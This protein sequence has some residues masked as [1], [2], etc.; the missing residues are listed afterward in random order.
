MAYCCVVCDTKTFS[1]D[2]FREHSKEHILLAQED[3]RKEV[4]SLSNDIIN[5]TELIN[6]EECEFEVHIKAKNEDFYCSL[7]GEYLSHWLYAKK[8][9]LDHKHCDGH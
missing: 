9:A 2:D 3:A 5:K 4:A 8:H 1:L 6:I 7:C